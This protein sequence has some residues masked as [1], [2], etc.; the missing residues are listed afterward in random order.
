MIV[1]QLLTVWPTVDYYS[2]P[3]LH[4]LCLH[5]LEHLLWQLILSN[6][7]ITS[8]C[9]IFY[10][11]HCTPVSHLQD[12]TRLAGF[13]FDSFHFET[14]TI[15]VCW[16]SPFDDFSFAATFSTFDPIRHHFQCTF[17][18]LKLYPCYS[19]D[20]LH[21]W[22]FCYKL[23]IISPHQMHWVNRCRL[24]LQMSVCS[25]ILIIYDIC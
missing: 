17:Q 18:I 14:D 7:H 19:W 13:F 25:V 1:N 15:F 16:L 24:L 20:W 22:Q 8:C 2:V 12:E 5:Q 10:C 9:T 4:Y 21:C 6:E 11:T 23:C 3:V